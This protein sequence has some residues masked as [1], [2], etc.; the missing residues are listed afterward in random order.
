MKIFARICLV[1]LIALLAAL[2]AASQENNRLAIATAQ[3]LD[4]PAPPPPTLKEV[5]EAIALDNQWRA[6]RLNSELPEPG[7]TATP[8]MLT[9]YW[10][11][12]AR[13]HPSRPVAE[14]ARWRLLEACF[15]DPRFE[16]ETVTFLPDTPP[17]HERV[18]QYLDQPHTEMRGAMDEDKNGLRYLRDWLMRHSGYYRDELIERAGDVRQDN[19]EWRGGDDLAALARLDWAAALPLIN[20]LLNSPDTGALALGLLYQHAEESGDSAQAESLRDRLQKIASDD[21]ASALAR[22]SAMQALI[23]SDWRG[24]DEWFLSLLASPASS[25]NRARFDVLAVPVRRDPDRWIP[26]LIRMVGHTNRA[27]HDAAAHCLSQFAEPDRAR[28]DA[29]AAL[30]L[31]LSDPDWATTPNERARAMLVMSLWDVWLPEATPRLISLLQSD[32]P[33]LRSEAAHVLGRHP[34]PRAAAALRKALAQA[35]SRD[36]SVEELVWALIQAGGLR[37]AEQIAALENVAIK[38]EVSVEYLRGDRRQLNIESDDSTRETI[39][40]IVCEQMA[41][42]PAVAAALVARWKRLRAINPRAAERLWLMLQEWDQPALALAD[43]E[44]IADGS[45][46]FETLRAALRHRAMLQAHATS[47]LQPLLARGGYRAGISAALLDHRATKAAILD[48]RDREARLALLAC[49]RLARVSLPVDRVAQLLTQSDNSL[50]VAAERYLESLDTP[51]ARRSLQAQH[52]DGPVILGARDSFDPKPEF[53]EAWTDWENEM[54]ERV[55]AH[56]ADEVFGQLTYSYSDDG[57]ESLDRIE[58]RVRGD[59]AEVCQRSNK[60]RW[61]KSENVRESCRPLARADVEAL[62]ALFAE[63]AFDDLPPIKGPGFAFGGREQEFVRINKS[64]GRRVYAADLDALRELETRPPKMQTP[65]ERVEA[66]F[67]DLVKGNGVQPR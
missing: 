20:R 25:N 36:D 62:R 2:P 3:L 41:G 15:E 6:E 26:I 66:F 55:K 53:R 54:R 1:G 24:R 30:L 10:A 22:R 38:G 42:T 29:I 43:A 65:H 59:E 40:Q 21:A 33:E 18:K 37:D 48:G 8:R 61:G 13:T 34:D 52:T 28:K 56:H 58:V 9:T 47:I 45:A 60:S 67:N 44:R 16:P 11:L 63:V 19:D 39:A 35:A 57:T 7:P 14:A 46:D 31:W 12:Q 64:D 27:I 17:A 50:R 49:S 23:E 32:E 5:T 51:A 4:H